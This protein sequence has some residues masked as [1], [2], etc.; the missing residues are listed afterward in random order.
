MNRLFTGGSFFLTLIL[1]LNQCWGHYI[2]FTLKRSF[3][4]LLTSHL[5][6]KRSYRWP[7]T[8]PG[9]GARADRRPRRVRR[10]LCGVPRALLGVSTG[11][12]LPAAEGPAGVHTGHHLRPQGGRG[13]SGKRVYYNSQGW[14]GVRY[15]PQWT[16]CGWRSRCVP[17][18]RDSLIGPQEG[19]SNLKA[20][21]SH[22]EHAVH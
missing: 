10:V 17:L 7:F 19:G 9:C 22:I 4:V 20:K 13:Q 8:P 16:V 15:E 6:Y 5:K 14:P 2:S 12:H 21:L 11:L 18:R 1:E 3:T